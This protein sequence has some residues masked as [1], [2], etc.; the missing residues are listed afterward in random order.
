MPDERSE[1]R[2]FISSTFRDLQEEREHLVKKIFTEIRAVCRARGITF[3]EVDLRWGI[4]DEEQRDGRVIR[5][6][7]EEVARCRPYF[8]GILG[9]RYG[10]VPTDDDVAADATL[11]ETRPWLTEATRDGLSLT[12]MEFTEGLFA[13]GS[14]ISDGAHV[15]RRTWNGQPHG[16]P[17]IEE[18]VARTVAG[19]YRVQEFADATALGS[20]VRSDLL[21]LVERIDPT[22]D[23]PS[24]LE[25]ERRSHA[26]FAAS[27]A[28]GYVERPELAESFEKWMR[29]GVAPL[30]VT[31]ASGVG[32]S[33]LV[34]SLAA[35]VRSRGND[36]FVFEHYTGASD[37]STSVD[38][39]I[40]H[41]LEAIRERFDL[42]EPVPESQHGLEEALQAW[43]YRLDHLAR[44]Q[45]RTA[46]IFLDAVDNL[47][48]RGRTMAWLPERLPSTLRIVLSSRP[49]PVADTLAARG[50]ATLDIGPL[51]DHSVRE[52]IVSRYL[53]G[54]RKRVARAE[55][56]RLIGAQC[57][58]S[59]LF[60]RV[61]AEEL[62]LHG[63]HET[64]ADVVDRYAAAQD[65]DELFTLVLERM[66]RDYG[67]E[68]VER[69][70]G[71]LFAARNGLSEH[72]LLELSGLSRIELSRLLF[73][74]DFHL[75]RRDALLGF[76]HDHL[77]RAVEHRYLATGITLRE[78]HAH[79]G[80][81]F[82]D[83][84]PDA[85]RRA[86]EPWQWQHAGE[87][88]RL[89]RTL[90][91]PV[92]FTLL[93][94]SRVRHELIGY[95]RELAPEH[96]PVEEYRAVLGRMREERVSAQERVAMIEGVAELHNASARFA[97]AEELLRVAYR[98]RRLT[99][100]PDAAATIRAADLLATTIYHA[101]RYAECEALWLTALLGLERAHGSDDTV[102]CDVLD[103]L[104]SCAYR[105]GDA[106]EMERYALRSLSISSEV[107]GRGHP[108]SIDRMINVGS[109]HLVAGRFDQAISYYD[110]AR[111]V[112][113][114]AFGVNHPVTAKC[115]TE[116]G[117]ALTFAERVQEAAVILNEAS[118]RTEELLGE[119]IA[120]ARV[121]ESLGH[122]VTRAGDPGRGEVIYRRAYRIRVELQGV[123]H[124][125]AM[126]TL[127][128]VAIAVRRS[129][130]PVEAE[131]IIRELL[132]RQIAICG[133]RDDNVMNTV[134]VLIN[135]LRM[136][137]REDEAEVW[138]RRYDAADV[139]E[140]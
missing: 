7:L 75:I 22:G 122:A 120:L 139:L 118:L 66:E 98:Y 12:A 126:F 68:P 134:F 26:A 9:T 114:R 3:T 110:A 95:W 101:G 47:E 57:A 11:V 53:G 94:E 83:Q 51:D 2:V 13:H 58:G 109:V 54:Y 80:A 19:G 124:P 99:D 70:L 78:W 27:R 60:L 133:P 63:T 20:L 97:P 67:R 89:A 85:R 38:G 39:M 29:D 73:A 84:S 21:A 18:L 103:N 108:L 37:S 91:D 127:S 107:H 28:H 5:T 135:I 116:L 88:D 100:G 71:L 36:P 105:R 61:V 24:S 56:H 115:H 82:A 106:D 40:R 93:N 14:T 137:N 123:D 81:Y 44:E 102:L 42:D 1:L 30:L 23:S 136:T 41:L 69:L 62:R 104:T 76:F 96:D 50:L 112:S 64:I 111:V 32:K 132:P 10:W 131:A 59:P 86:E 6:C 72:E 15:Y 46:V 79:I 4:T 74:L 90:R 125:D 8:I 113:L 129:G 45:E 65:V 35:S 77:R 17:G 130:R 16:E 55:L 49:G 34:A 48:E 43:L 128:R 31:G 119:H 140:E 52:A 87:R 138:Q 33:S 92:L 25:L 121:L 117:V